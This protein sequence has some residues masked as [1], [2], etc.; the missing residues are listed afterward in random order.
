V[1]SMYVKG[2]EAGGAIT[3][4]QHLLDTAAD[5]ESR[6][7]LERQLLQ[8]RVEQAAATIDQ[9][10]ARYRERYVLSPVTLEQLVFTG[11]LPAIPPDPAGGTWVLDEEGRA[12]S[13]VY[14][15]RFQ[16]PMT[17]DERRKAV[18]SLSRNMRGQGTP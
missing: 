15:K 13:T 10:V 1:L 14:T 11:I 7:S 4:L 2:E 3:F 6:R 17:D 12:H 9:A 5:D 18:R 8:A 16:R